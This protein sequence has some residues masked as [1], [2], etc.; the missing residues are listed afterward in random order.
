[1]RRIIRAYLHNLADGHELSFTRKRQIRRQFRN[2]IR[3]FFTLA[4]RVTK[5]NFY[6]RSFALWHVLHIPLVFLMIVAVVVHI[7]AV[8]LF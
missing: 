3:R 6:E 2:R 8:H 4:F 1:M 7:I 5:F